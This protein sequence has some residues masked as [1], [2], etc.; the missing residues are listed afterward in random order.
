MFLIGLL[1][2]LADGWRTIL[3]VE[4]VRAITLISA[5]RSRTNESLARNRRRADRRRSVVYAV[6]EQRDRLN[7]AS[8]EPIGFNYELTLNY[9]RSRI[10][11]TLALPILVAIVALAA[12]P[13]ADLTHI[14]MWA[15]AVMASHAIT[16]AACR[17]YIRLPAVSVDIK[18]WQLRFVAAELLSGI[19]WAAL[20]L[21]IPL[22]A[23]SFGLD[24]FQFAAMLMFVAVTTSLSSTIPMAAMA[25]SVP[26]TL[27]L[28]AVYMTHGQ[29][30]YAALV[31]AALCVLFIILFLT[32]RINMATLAVL[33]T[34][35]EKD[36]LIAELGTA[37]SISDES[38][39]RAEEA[40]LA[41]SR[42]LA[43]MSHELRTPLN[44]II[45]FS[46]VIEQELLGPVG[47]ESYKEYVSD[48]H[49]SGRYLL[50]LINEILDLSRIEAGRA[51]LNEE[52]VDLQAV[53][54]DCQRLT[55]L[56][57]K[58]KRISVTQ[59][60]APDLPP[61]LA[62]EQAVRQ[63]VLNLLSNALK[64]TPAGGAIDLRV[65][66]TPG[67][68]LAL[69]VRDNGPGIPAGEIP[70]VLSSFGQGA[71]SIKNAE[72]GAGLGLT[73]V[74]ALMATHGGTFELRSE[75]RV[76]T[77]AVATFPAARVI[78]AAPLAADEHPELQPMQ[79]TG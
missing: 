16:L 29:F 58:A 22:S 27:A 63:I 18:S 28:A 38:R 64:F 71:I 59:D 34:R 56:K 3:D 14:A 9:A 35:A 49:K 43:T 19:S 24:V 52:T 17:H 33:E 76:G 4:R 36:L 72:R 41:K 30:L 54:A 66:P 69:S 23:T 42:F 25:G 73:I 65:Q 26:A 78:A 74:Q 32:S 61:I 48:I 2:N 10:A 44:A 53:V 6:R 68:G 45:G 20:F 51:D 7:S 77:E 13:W 39:R 62:D 5:Q 11:A 50:K 79:M 40:N 46:E 55:R 47:H 21:L 31:M 75:L 70:V 8:G 12:A 37:K 60:F 15:S 67:G 1:S 57:A